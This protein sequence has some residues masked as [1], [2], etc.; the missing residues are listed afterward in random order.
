MLTVSSNLCV[1]SDVCSDDSMEANTG[2]ET[3]YVYVYSDGTVVDMAPLKV[4]SSCNLDIYTFPFDIQNCSYS[5]NSYL[6]AGK[7]DPRFEW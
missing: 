7:L 1:V 5:F 6:H 3:Y 2:P 4:I